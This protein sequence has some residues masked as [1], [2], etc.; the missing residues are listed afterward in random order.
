MGAI[1]SIGAMSTSIAFLI[2]GVSE[3]SKIDPNEI[4]GCINHLLNTLE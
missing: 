1:G 3:S 2:K 4:M